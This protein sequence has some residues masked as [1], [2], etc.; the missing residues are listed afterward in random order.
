[1]IGS[2]LVKR[3]CLQMRYFSRGRKATSERL[4]SP[5]RL[6]HY[7]NTWYL[8]AWCHAAKGLRRFALDAIEQAEVVDDA[9]KDVPMDKLEEAFDRG[10][11]VI[12]GDRIQRA[13]ILFDA[14]TARWVA[15][16]VWHPLQK[17]TSLPD[18]RYRLEVPYA[19]PTE[20]IMDVLRQGAHA[21]IE[22]PKELKRRLI[23]TLVELQRKYDASP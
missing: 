4:V 9:C 21:T 13:T 2:A 11:G 10:Y 19:E 5:Q 12:T 23:E 20:L 7:R 17:G 1:M 3:R 8:D 16:E 6:V 14:E 18:G 15:R 22:A